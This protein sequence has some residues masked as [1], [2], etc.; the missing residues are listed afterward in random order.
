MAPHTARPPPSACRP[1]RPSTSRFRSRTPP[2]P[3]CTA[4]TRR[5]ARMH[6]FPSSRAPHCCTALRSQ[7]L[8]SQPSAA[9]PGGLTSPSSPLPPPPGSLFGEASHRPAGVSLRRDKTVQR[10]DRARVPPPPR[11]QAHRPPLLH[12]LRPA[13]PA[14][15]G[16][17][18]LHAGAAHRPAATHRPAPPCPLPPTAQ[19][20]PAPPP[21]R[22]AIL[23]GKQ[24]TEYR[25]TDGTELQRDFTCTTATR[26]A[27]TRHRTPSLTPSAPP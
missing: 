23:A 10:A 8:R 9:S 26:P 5:L 25:N 14:R 21:Y 15:H 2:R 20:L 22:Q 1:S 4:S 24:L 12:R 16:I 6:R 27:A 18:L 13:R 3:P 17:L 7:P 11:P 19:P